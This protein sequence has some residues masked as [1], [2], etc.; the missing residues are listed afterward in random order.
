MKSKN[1]AFLGIL[2][3]VFGLPGAAIAEIRQL[4]WSAVTTYTD[5]SQIEAGQTV[6]YKAYWTQDPWLAAETLRP[7]VSSTTAT[8]ATFDPASEGM[9]GYQAVYFT[10]K[11]VVGTGTEST[12]SAALP[13]TPP[14]A[15]PGEPSAP[16][17]LGITRIGTSTP[18]GTWQLSW[19]AVTTYANGT[20]I[21]GKTARYAIFW[22]ADAGLP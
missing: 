4:A 7:L 18:S 22:T 10:V 21:Q 15:I 17:D 12:F 20:P 16:A 6:R 8:S 11:T 14:P 5:G 19:G 13:W 1:I 3:F 2:L 9:V